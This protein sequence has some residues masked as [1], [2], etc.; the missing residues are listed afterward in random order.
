MVGPR[1]SENNTRNLLTLNPCRRSIK[2]LLR[3]SVSNWM[4]S[5]TMR[6][7]GGLVSKVGEVR[8]VLGLAGRR[9]GRLGEGA[10]LLAGHRPTASQLAAFFQAV[11]PDPDLDLD[12]D[13]D[14]EIGPDS[15]HD[16]VDGADADSEA[17]AKASRVATLPSFRPGRRPRTEPVAGAVP[18]PSPDPGPTGRS[19]LRALSK[20]ARPSLFRAVRGVGDVGGARRTGFDPMRRGGAPG[21]AGFSRRDARRARGLL[22]RQGKPRLRSSEPKA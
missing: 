14:P 19:D 18:G 6:H 22:I 1:D 12:P 16:H 21:K 10:S 9:F 11:Y 3:I 17:S 7:T 15:D 4:A 5:D 8:R 20:R 2:S 13:A